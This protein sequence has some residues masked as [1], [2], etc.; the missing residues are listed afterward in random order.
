MVGVSGPQHC[1]CE[2]AGATAADIVAAAP[3]AADAIEEE[4]ESLQIAHKEV[5]ST[6]VEMKDETAQPT[7]AN[8]A[9]SELQ[10]ESPDVESESLEVS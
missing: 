1:C 7:D 8:A 10:S 5:E 4:V 2:A 9:V 3:G 6:D